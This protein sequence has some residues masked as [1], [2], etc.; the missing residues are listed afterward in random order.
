L[1]LEIRQRGES[2]DQQPNGYERDPEQPLSF[3]PRRRQRS[4]PWPLPSTIHR[5]WQSKSQ[6]GLKR[7]CGVFAR[8]RL[9]M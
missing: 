5:S 9:T 8:Q 4:P 3:L 6:A 7:F 2:N 1:P